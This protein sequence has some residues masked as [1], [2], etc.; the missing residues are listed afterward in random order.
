MVVA[1]SEGERNTH[2]FQEW[3]TEEQDFHFA[4]CDAATA[5]V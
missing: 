2:I 4:N 5:G 1:L 3:A